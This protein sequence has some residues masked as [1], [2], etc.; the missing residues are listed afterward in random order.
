VSTDLYRIRVLDI[1]P[2]Q[3][4]VRFRVFMVYYPWDFPADPSF[5][6][7]ILRDEADSESTGRGS[8]LAAEITLDQSLDEKWIDANTARFIEGVE[9]VSFREHRF[10]GEP[11]NFI[12]KSF[13]DEDRLTQG[14]F[15][16]TVSDP[17]WLKHLFPG[18]TWQTTCYE[19]RAAPPG[20]VPA[21]SPPAS[22]SARRAQKTPRRAGARRAQKAAKPRSR[23]GRTAKA[24]LP[25]KAKPA[26]KA[27]TASKPKR[28]R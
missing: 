8:P 28:G 19:S 17:R 23:S 16:V 24:K 14:D 1:D 18:Q 4:K 12:Y 25:A 26:P 11:P 22:V 27:R 5:F 3:R 7:R 15:D 13:A 9:R 20:A 6:L 2:R 21:P 10:D